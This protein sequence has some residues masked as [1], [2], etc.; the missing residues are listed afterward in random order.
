MLYGKNSSLMLPDSLFRNPTSEYRGAPFW[1]WN[2]TLNKEEMCRQIDVMQKMGLGGYHMHVRTG[3]DTPYLSDDFMQYIR[4][5]VTEAQSRGMLAWLYDE[6]R[7]PS[8]AA[9]GLVTKDER[10]RAR[11]LLFTAMPY[12]SVCD[13]CGGVSKTVAMAQRTQKGQLLACYDVELNDD[14]SLA[15]YS[16][17]SKDAPI[18]GTRWY[19][20]LETATPSGWFNNQTYVNTLDKRAIDRFIEITYNAYEKTVGEEMGKTV[21]AIFTDEPQFVHKVPLRYAKDRTDVFFPWT[22]DLTDTFREVYGEDLLAELPQLVWNLP[23]DEAS[24]IRYH[25]HDY[26]CER[27]TEAFAD[28]CG[29]W[30]RAHGLKLTGHM[31]EEPTL[32]SQT[33]ALGEA[34]RAYRGFDLPGIDMLCANFEYTT[35][36]QTQSAVHQFGYEGMLSELY[37]VTNWD[38]DFRGHKLHGDWQ[39]A[40]GVTVRVQH[41][42]WMSMKGEAKRDYPASISYQSPWWREYSLIENHFARLNTALTRGT[43]CVRV[44]VIHPVESY[45]LHWGPEDV[46]GAAKESLDTLFQSITQWLLFGFIDFDFISEALL[47]DQCAEGGAPLKVGNMAYD[48][49]LV[50]GCE[51]LRSTTLSRLEAFQR[52]GGQL[53][54]VGD[55]PKWENAMSSDRGAR[56]YEKS[57]H[58]AADRSSLLKALQPVRALEARDESGNY[59]SNLLYQ[60]RSDNNGLWLFVAH[61]KEPYNKD[62]CAHS[63][64]RLTIYG[65]FCPECYDTSTGEH[66]PMA[67]T[68]NSG[69]TEITATL[70]DYD[71]LLL[72]LRPLSSHSNQGHTITAFKQ[73]G[74]Q[75][76][77]PDVVPF[78]LDEPNA[79]LLDRAEFALDDDQYRPVTELL[80]A[81]NICR[82][83]LNLPGRQERFAQ[84]WVVP[85]EPIVHTLHLRF[86]V[87]SDLR[88]EGAYL[89]LEDADSVKISFNGQTVPNEI[90]G[91]YTD[92]SIGCVPLPA[93][94]PGSN[95]LELSVPFGQRTN[96]EWVYIVG[97]FGVRVQGSRSTLIAATRELG[98]SD[99]CS[100][101]LPFYGGNI[102]YHVRFTTNGGRVVMQCPHYRG[103]LLK[104]Q[105]DDGE[106]IPI[107]Y[108]PYSVDFGQLA[109]GE[110][111]AHITL[112]GHRKNAFG[113]VH[114]ADKKERW[115]GPNAWRSSDDRW[116][117][118]YSICKVGLMSEPR[119]FETD[120]E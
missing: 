40:L 24:A 114:L 20:Y 89:A 95:T 49:I 104:A 23:K 116:C 93:L 38:F 94:N 80:R 64:V 35:A 12:E 18:R 90:N 47:P 111:T 63:E 107:I 96:I 119:F 39:A 31:M 51:T 22:D 72:Y 82:G 76:L 59:T 68:H 103:A 33:A 44:G 109:A 16:L 10:F 115:I 28:N 81:D 30:C 120:I 75:L 65:D 4:Y 110:H 54:F 21:P 70:Y 67:H 77:V 34:M 1:A 2:C 32:R 46:S 48:A 92:R 83:E 45:W 112:F 108:P 6:D 98:F 60:L 7:W 41:L 3:L 78:T 58:V 69:N 26:V 62:V 84:P 71:S 29:A 101:G 57:Q 85:A 19:A 27:F 99:F 50:P 88:L 66:Y 79:L 36:K 14:G 53:I 97:D 87:Y 118:S 73:V 55:A 56:L 113:P 100:Q 106:V 8:G 11:H 74:R 117:E 25:Y 91:W 37:G 13:D 9:G 61:G 86:T 5:C 43:P 17:V 105:V 52:A 102:T 42:A 15:Y